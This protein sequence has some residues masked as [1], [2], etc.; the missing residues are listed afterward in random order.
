MLQ[1][2][3]LE[4]LELTSVSELESLARKSPRLRREENRSEGGDFLRS[5]LAK[6]RPVELPF[7]RIREGHGQP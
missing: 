6:E 2:S 1:G 4:T 3:I 5:G 7:G